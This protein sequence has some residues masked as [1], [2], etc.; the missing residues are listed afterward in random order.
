MCVCVCVCG[1]GGGVCRRLSQWWLVFILLGIDATL[2][3]RVCEKFRGS[4][5]SPGLFQDFMDGYIKL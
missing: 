4:E 2:S 5:M 1:G 3:D